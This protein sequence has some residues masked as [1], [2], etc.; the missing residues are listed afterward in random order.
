MRL[1]HFLFVSIA[2]LLLL[3]APAR[4]DWFV[5]PMIGGNF[6]GDAPSTDRKPAFGVSFG[7]MGAG[8][9]GFEGQLMYTNQFF[10]PKSVIGSNNVTS[11]MGNVIVGAPI[12]DVRQF[13]PY[14]S[15]GVGLLRSRIGGNA[16]D[17][18]DVSSND[19][20]M[21]IGGG[22]MVFLSPNVGLRG[23]LRYFRSING[24]ST[25]GLIPVDVDLGSFHFWQATGGVAFRF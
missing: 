11:L 3:P 13:R 18:F 23:D 2:A 14:V 15:G 20:G 10:A 21:N 19:F 9:V 16:G 17:L 6:G 22:G 8:I 7:Y 24:S 12:G 25:N 4:A 5:S 1:R